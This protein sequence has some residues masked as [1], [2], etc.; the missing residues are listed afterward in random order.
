MSGSGDGTV[1]WRELLAEATSR[2]E[3]VG[4]AGDARRIVEEASGASPAELALVLDDPVTTRALARFDEMLARRSVGEPLQYVLGRW[5]FRGLDLMVDHRVL[6]PRP[7]TEQVVQAALGELDALG[8]GD[9]QRTVVDLGTGSGAIALSIASER[10]RTTVWATDASPAALEVARANLAG[11]GRAAARVTMVEGDW[12]DA[13]P[14]ELRGGVHLVV[15][16]P[17]YVASSAG[18]PREVA[19]WEPVGALLAGPDGLDDLRRI[20]AGAGE[21][22]VDEGALVCEISPEQSEAVAALAA[23]HFAAARVAPDLAGRPRA[24][25]ARGPLR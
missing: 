9:G 1:C 18:L 16:N 22:L 8:V 3:G 5:G 12:F 4:H 24:L 25:V 17:P 23:G 2:L 10:A 7:E 13:L 15:S 20:I 6:I 14:G 19:D 11:I 21:W